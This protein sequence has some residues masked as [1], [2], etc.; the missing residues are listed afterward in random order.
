MNENLRKRIIDSVA[1]APN[2]TPE[3]K[4]TAINF[5]KPDD[6]MSVHSEERSVVKRLLAHP[7]FEIEIIQQAT[8]DDV[9]TIDSDDLADEFDGR[10]KTV[11]VTGSMPIGTLWI[12]AS[13]RQNTRHSL[14]VSDTAS[15]LSLTAKG[16]D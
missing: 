15:D 3:E 6:R 13:P 12:K 14:L 9:Y 16:D 5:S 10:R 2:R 11:A 1:E 4:E 8:N 7:D